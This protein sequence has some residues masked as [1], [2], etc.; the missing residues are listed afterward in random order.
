MLA[1]VCRCINT[2][3]WLKRHLYHLG[4]LPSPG[5]AVDD[6][7]LAL[8]LKQRQERNSAYTP[9]AIV[10][11]LRN[12]I[13]GKTYHESAVNA[14]T[15]L[16]SWMS[17]KHLP[18]V[19]SCSDLA[20]K[21]VIQ[22]DD[23]EY[24]F[25]LRK[26]AH[27]LVLL[28]GSEYA[29]TQR[30]L[31]ASTNRKWEKTKAPDMLKEWPAKVWAA[32]PPSALPNIVEVLTSFIEKG[33]TVEKVNEGSVPED[34]DSEAPEPEME[35]G[36]TLESCEDSFEESEERSFA[37][38]EI[39]M[40]D[41][42]GVES[43]ISKAC[44][45]VR[46]R[47][48]EME[49]LQQPFDFP[50][51]KAQ[52]EEFIRAK[53]ADL[54][55]LSR[56]ITQGMQILDKYIKEAMERI[57]RR[58]EPKER[59]KLMIDLNKHLEDDANHLGILTIEWLNKI[60][61]RLEELTQQSTLISEAA[62]RSSSN[63]SSEQDS[64]LQTQADRC[65]RIRRPL[66]E[67]PTFSGDF[68]EFATF[69][70]VFKSLVHDDAELSDQEKFLLLKQALKGKAAASVSSIPVIGERYHVAVNILKKQY[71]RSSSMA[72]ILISEIERIPR[73]ND[74]PK[75]CRETLEFAA[76]WSV[77]KSLVHD[78]AELSDQEKFLFLKQALKGKAAALR[79][80]LKPATSL[81]VGAILPITLLKGEV[82][83]LPGLRLCMEMVEHCRS[84][85]EKA[86][87]EVLWKPTDVNP[88]IHWYPE[89]PT[90]EEMKKLLKDVER[91]QQAAACAIQTLMAATEYHPYMVAT[92]LGLPNGDG[93]LHMSASATQVGEG[94]VDCQGPDSSNKDEQK[95]TGTCIQQPLLS[96][97]L[98]G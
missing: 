73:A 79:E 54:N 94:L 87:F 25:D 39:Q 89:T 98:Y 15:T 46:S 82:N 13:Y 22:V 50:T 71:D 59:E 48:A 53:T 90:P 57:D 7:R 88:E 8:M 63:S 62:A 47:D 24:S 10:C 2:K 30:V 83:L 21:I 34:D 40:A 33:E 60:E 6:M 37:I 42:Q 55:Y 41:L 69:W 28:L 20:G 96:T 77:F 12:I 66:L 76:F 58:E 65:Q 81:T 84:Y 17:A 64:R 31:A 16:M 23:E 74:N 19:L 86:V 49:K 26:C 35:Y 91:C 78:D 93:A 43:K 45:L 3:D 29:P 75:S 14:I 11:A 95:R 97:L 4:P 80:E 1:S 32:T 70:S 44:A 27:C 61:F 92:A 5:P 51:E 68:G 52:C 18:A 72:D 67:V 85:D 38:S 9:W 56:G 36:L